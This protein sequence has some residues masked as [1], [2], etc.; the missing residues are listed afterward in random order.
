MSEVTPL[1]QMTNI[2]KR[3]PGVKAL[4]D[5]SLRLFSGEVHA[6]MGEN[7]AGKSTLI[8]VLTGVYSI[9]E[10]TVEMEGNP[11]NIH[12]PLESQAAGISTVYQEVNLCPNLTV[13]ENIFIGREP[14]K[15]G[16][17]CWKEMNRRAEELLKDRL[18]LDIDVDQPL[19]MYSV[20]V[21][22][23]IAIARALNISAKVLILDEPTSSLDKNEV[24]QL[25]LVLR[26]L[27]SDG[28]A[29]LFVTHFLDQMYEISDRVTI[30]RNG[31]F[32]GEYLAEDLTRLDLVLKMIGKELNLLEELPVLSGT[33]KDKPSE[34][35]LKAEGL[36]RKGAIE[37][38][39]LTINKG[40]V[41]GLAGLLG[42][43]RTEAARL[44]F[45]ADKADTGKL[46]FADGGESIHSP[47][48]AIHRQIAFCSENRKTEGI[49]GDLT[50]RENIVLALQAKQGWFKTIS[51]K[52][53]DEIVD[54]Y[55][56]ILNINP[57]NPD[58]LIKNLS[59]GNQQKVLLA[60]WLL[61]EPNLLILDEPTRGIDIG[62]KAEI[63]K[64]V[65]SLSREGMSF[66][67]ISAELEE[68]IR[69][70]DKIAVLRDR[71][72]VTEISNKDMNQH[73]IMQAIAGS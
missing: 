21:Q 70:S 3:F 39:N 14:R 56:R 72:V 9:D 8:K 48:D 51:R 30:L 55:I 59:G 18:N 65:L 33:N 43:G 19:Y 13:A 7:G 25:F 37:P 11:I 54:E 62:A 41:V 52:R 64:L 36:G 58:H 10:G 42:S 38:F 34:E 22:Q 29:I 73:T 53:Q 68:V 26:K 23:L 16:R 47:R 61:T 45:G 32:V 49:I 69:V 67:F 40:E 27:K 1:L 4:S 63:Q 12:S 50:I 28:L 44:L 15:L 60:R 2:H 24:E 5:V 71:H 66:V 46:K 20:A 17:I 31:G 35:L 6:L 57:P